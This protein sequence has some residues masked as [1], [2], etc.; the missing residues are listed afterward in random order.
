MEKEL[1]TSEKK[2]NKTRVTASC[3]FHRNLYV[4]L[5]ARSVVRLLS[6]KLYL[7]NESNLCYFK[8]NK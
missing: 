4:V 3:Q 1:I 7:P 2:F 5:E 8:S 6:I